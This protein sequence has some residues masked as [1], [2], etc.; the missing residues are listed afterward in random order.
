[1][2][3]GRLV[4]VGHAH[5]TAAQPHLGELVEHRCGRREHL[6]A[7]QHHREGGAA[8]RVGSCLQEVDRKSTRLNSSHEWSSYAVFCLKKKM[9]NS[10]LDHEPSTYD[11]STAPLT[12]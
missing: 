2:S 4:E 12:L 5:L 8:T 6:H 11:P 10:A 3:P 9:K 7:W 1:M